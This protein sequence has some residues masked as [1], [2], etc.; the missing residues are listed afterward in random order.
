MSYDKY[1]P[2]LIP[3]AFLVYALL[4]VCARGVRIRWCCKCCHADEIDA[5]RVKHPLVP[6]FDNTTGTFLT[7]YTNF[8]EAYEF[9][10]TGF[11]ASHEA[12]II[13]APAAPDEPPPGQADP[14]AP[15][16]ALV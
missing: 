14:A 9:M 6:E 13:A 10:K 15:L 5:E 3:A 7:I 4:V 11:V 12:A 16:S 2:L 1:S 8:K